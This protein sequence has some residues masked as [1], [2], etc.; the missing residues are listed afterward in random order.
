MSHPTA[1]KDEQSIFKLSSLSID[2]EIFDDKK[3]LNYTYVKSETL[4]STG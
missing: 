1:G 4:S 3:K 2:L